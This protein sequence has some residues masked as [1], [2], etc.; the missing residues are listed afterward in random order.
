MEYISVGETAEKWGVSL[1]QVQRLLAANRIPH[2]KK[3]GRAWMIPA[4]AAKPDD[5][6]LKKEPTGNSFASDFDYIVAST[7]RYVPWKVPDGSNTASEEWL[8]LLY[9]EVRA[10]ACG[11]F[12][13]VLRCF[14]K[15][16]EGGAAKLRACQLATVAAASLGDYPL[17]LE[18]ESY[19]KSVVRANISD[20]VSAVAELSL[21]TA[22]LGV[23]APNMIH[24]WLKDG[25]FTAL[26]AQV[27]PEAINQRVLYF[28]WLGKYQSML[29]VAQTALG[30]FNK[31][32]KQSLPGIYLRL[33]CAVACYAIGRTDEA[34]RW[35][36]EAM[37]ICLP[38]GVITP[39]A[40]RL[41]LLGGMVERSLQREFPERY[42]A[43]IEH[44]QRTFTNLLAFHNRFTKDNITLILSL[45]E[46]EVALLTARG[47]PN[48]KIAERFHLSVGRI[49]NIKN[50]IYGKLSVKNRKELAQHILL[51]VSPK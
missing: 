46:Y 39:F 35:L 14:H 15:H 24:R 25:D 43:V 1:R 27:K 12:E 29:D 32:Q 28:R 2:A 18:I 5:P 45:R 37:R 3:H 33:S 13:Q 31:Q 9:E 23:G 42:S 38:H 30:F 21:S 48:A 20:A 7:N 36:L 22:Y 16:E 17:Y 11:D 34:K 51:E 10:Y 44:C 50:E 49:K 6:R 41:P 19:L 8:W 4:D 40:Q 26:P 47:I